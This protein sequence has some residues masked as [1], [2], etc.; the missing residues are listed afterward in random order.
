[1]KS[2]EIMYL[3]FVMFQFKRK[4]GPG[5]GVTGR[6]KGWLGPVK[7]VRKP[8]IGRLGT[9]VWSIISPYTGVCWS[10]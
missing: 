5:V 7:T 10:L 3:C 8:Y 2:R 4:Q 9:K 1:M 6:R